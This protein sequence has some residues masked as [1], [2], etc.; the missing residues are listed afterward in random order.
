MKQDHFLIFV[1]NVQLE[2]A[3]SSVVV[4]DEP[5]LLFCFPKKETKKGIRQ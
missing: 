1:I 5:L 2:N 3:K 4:L